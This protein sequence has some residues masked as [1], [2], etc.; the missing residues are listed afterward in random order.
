ML[1][2]LNRVVMWG[3]LP[4]VA[5]L[6]ACSTHTHSTTTTT[7]DNT[8]A[9]TLIKNTYPKLPPAAGMVRLTEG[10]SVY[11]KDKNLNLKFVKVLAD[12]RCPQNST[13]VWAGN[14]TVVIEA[15]TNGTRPQA[16]ELS[17]GDMRGNL[18]R[19]RPFDG[20]TISLETLYP[21]P[22]TAI[23]FNQIQGKYMVDLKV[24]P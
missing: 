10:Q 8:P 9:V 22:T 7:L 3:I 23:G 4:T 6:T 19:Q 1:I 5:A 13:C 16:L 18:V 2:H 14:A 11:L 12:S 17:T 24:M 21:T 15:M 20:K